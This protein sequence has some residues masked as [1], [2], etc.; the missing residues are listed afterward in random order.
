MRD[1]LKYTHPILCINIEM[2]LDI[3]CA[4]EYV[5]E[6]ILFDNIRSLLKLCFN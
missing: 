5:T 2:P 4:R 6:K 3:N 1:I